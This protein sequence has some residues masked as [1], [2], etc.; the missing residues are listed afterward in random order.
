MIRHI[1][2]LAAFS[3]AVPAVAQT[4]DAPAG[5]VAG[6]AQGDLD[7]F[8]GIPYAA[9]P[10][11]KL[12]W[13]AP[14]PLPRWQGVRQATRFGPGCIVPTPGPVKTVY[15]GDPLPTSEDCLT[16]NIWAPKHAENAPV[17]RSLTLSTCEGVEADGERDYP[18][19]EGEVRSDDAHYPKLGKVL[20]VGQLLVSFAT[21]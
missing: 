10:V 13:T 7:V 14:K 17:F 18:Q 20:C 21:P 19:G 5:K 15:S 12:R 4:V 2:A 9:P 3:L 6:A 1:A 16:L 8:K 11:G